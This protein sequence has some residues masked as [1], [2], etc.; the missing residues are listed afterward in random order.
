MAEEEMIRTKAGIQTTQ[1]SFI[2]ETKMSQSRV[3]EGPELN[4]AQYA[5]A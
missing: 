1:T 2:H 4:T 3:R 5:G